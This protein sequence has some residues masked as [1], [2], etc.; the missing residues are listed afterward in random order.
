[1]T[2]AKKNYTKQVGQTSISW[3][4][5]D[6]Q[7]VRASKQAPPSDFWLQRNYFFKI[8]IGGKIKPSTCKLFMNFVGS[9]IKC[10]PLET[11]EEVAL[12]TYT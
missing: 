7:I 11:E 6:G 8:A 1:M 5:S 9:V 3:N 10:C 2:A 4:S 12:Q